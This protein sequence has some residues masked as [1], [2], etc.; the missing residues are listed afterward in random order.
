MQAAMGGACSIDGDWESICRM[1]SMDQDSDFINLLGHGS[2]NYDHNEEGSVALKG[3]KKGR[4]KKNRDGLGVGEL[5]ENQKSTNCD[6]ESD[7]DESNDSQEGIE[8]GKKKKR[9]GRGAA[10]D[11]QSLYAR[12]RRERINERLRILQ[13][14]VPNGTK[15]D[16]STM[17]EDAVHYVKFLQMQIK[18]LSSDEMWMYA[19]LAYH[20]IDVGLYNNFSPYLQ[21]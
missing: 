6:A 3:K 1:L 2:D 8:S 7:D 17:L 10:T 14:L 12:R 19:P 15:V 20:G 5:E 18:L 13:T 9:A 4:A 11:P 16:I 21:P